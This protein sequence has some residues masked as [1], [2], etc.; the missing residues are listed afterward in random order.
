MCITEVCESFT[1]SLKVPAVALFYE[2]IP[3]KVKKKMTTS[4]LELGA[5]LGFLHVQRGR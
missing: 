1:L 3:D 4:T 2:Y 5:C